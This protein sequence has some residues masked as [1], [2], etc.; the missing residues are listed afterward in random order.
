MTEE[1]ARGEGGGPRASVGG[2]RGPARPMFR[3]HCRALSKSAFRLAGRGRHGVR[4][5]ASRGTAGDGSQ[6]RL[7]NVKSLLERF[8]KQPG[9][10]PRQGRV[11]ERCRSCCARNQS[12]RSYFHR[13]QD[14]EGSPPA[15]HPCPGE[16]AGQRNVTV[17]RRGPGCPPGRALTQRSVLSGGMFIPIPGRV[18]SV[19]GR[20]P[21]P[22]VR[23]ASRGRRPARP[24][25]V[26]NWPGSAIGRRV[27]RERRPAGPSSSARPVSSVSA[28]PLHC[29]LVGPA[30]EVAEPVGSRQCLQ[31]G[32]H[33]LDGFRCARAMLGPAMERAWAQRFADPRAEALDP[34]DAGLQPRPVQRHFVRNANAG[35]FDP[36]RGPMRRAAV[37]RSI[38]S[39]SPS[40]QSTGRERRS[41][42]SR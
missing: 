15:A 6:Y 18:M 41:A 8:R 29:P 19:S 20:C 27:G 1:C 39:R 17:L 30:D 14:S 33:V 4:F 7:Q 36:E 3:G 28:D 16:R 9:Q 35:V 13:G 12:N 40:V 11:A 25:T 10:W 5:R 37:M 2:G 31:P 42:G 32:P 24:D 26:R 22:P 38:A 21:P 34:L 23:P